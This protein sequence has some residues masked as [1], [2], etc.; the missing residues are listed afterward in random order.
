MASR[1]YCARWMVIQ[2]NLIMLICSVV[3]LAIGIWTMNDKSFVD[4]LLRNRLYMNSTYI[5][6]ISACI[7]IPL[8]SFG[9]FAAFKEVKCLLLTHFVTTLLLFVALLVGGIVAYVFKEQVENTMI[10]EM[11]ADIRNYDPDNPEDPVTKAWDQTQRELSCCGLMTEQVT[12]SWQMWRYNRKLNPSAEYQMVPASCCRPDPN[13]ECFDSS[14]M[15]VVEDSLVQGDC[16]VLTLHYV[17]G[18]A[19]TLGG[20]AVGV[21]AILIV[22]MAASLTLFK[23]IV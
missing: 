11:I 2:S 5:I 21:S 10:A 14:N 9:C 23:S 7:M 22:I 4:E 17:R 13:L 6:L 12:M 1:P 18:H 8:S 3:L 15:T 16:Y 19:S 20:A